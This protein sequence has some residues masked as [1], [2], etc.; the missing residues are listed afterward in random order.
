MRS[1][2]IVVVM[3]VCALGLARSSAAIVPGLGGGA[4]GAPNDSSGELGPPVEGPLPWMPNSPE[5][6]YPTID[7]PQPAQTSAL[8]CIGAAP[9]CGAASG[10]PKPQDIVVPAVP[11]PST[12]A[13]M[14]SGFCGLVFLAYRRRTRQTVRVA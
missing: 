8:P 13:M 10:G 14:I 3:L 7:N 2:K 12:W 6:K 5:L 1:L 4:S 11:E 9:N